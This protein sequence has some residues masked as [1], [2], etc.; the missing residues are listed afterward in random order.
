MGRGRGQG[1]QAQQAGAA[2]FGGPQFGRH[3]L[4]CA[5]DVAGV[6]DHNHSG[7]CRQGAPGPAL[8]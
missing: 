4:G 3:A 2:F 8:E 6:A 5:Q 7:I 1:A